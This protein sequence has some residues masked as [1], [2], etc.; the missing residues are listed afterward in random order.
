M[1]IGD[2]NNNKSHLVDISNP[3]YLPPVLNVNLATGAREVI[4]G[5]KNPDYIDYNKTEKKI[6]DQQK[7]VITKTVVIE[8]KPDKTVKTTTTTV[9]TINKKK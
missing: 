2:L 9:T 6:D 5:V 3:K 1:Q 4:K 8:K 7:K